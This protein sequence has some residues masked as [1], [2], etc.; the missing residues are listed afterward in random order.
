MWTGRSV[1]MRAC[2]TSVVTPSSVATLK[3]TEPLDSKTQR[4]PQSGSAETRPD[5]ASSLSVAGDASASDQMTAPAIGSEAPTVPPAGSDPACTQSAM[6][7]PMASLARLLKAGTRMKSRVTSPRRT[8]PSR[9]AGWVRPGSTP[10]TALALRKAA[11]GGAT[12]AAE[13]CT[14][15][16]ESRE[17]E[18]APGV[19]SSR[20]N[21]A[22]GRM[23]AATAAGCSSGQLVALATAQCGRASSL[24]TRA[25]SSQAST[26]WSSADTAATSSRSLRG[27]PPSPAHPPA[28]PSAEEVEAL[29]PYLAWKLAPMSTL[30]WRHCPVGGSRVSSQWILPPAEPALKQTV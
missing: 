29:V 20:L 2:V 15:E 11:L 28:T 30:T 18:L 5:P 9:S 21:R 23:R 13:R 19:P 22:E 1:G 17:S 12:L 27:T 24:T 26:G 7:K 6:A 10:G 25:S 4:V 8:A 16:R 14:P 3:A